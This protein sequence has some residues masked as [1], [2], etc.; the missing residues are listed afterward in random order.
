MTLKE[1]FSEY[2]IT[3]EAII[4]FQNINDDYD[5]GDFRHELLSYLAVDYNFCLVKD[6]P[7][8]ILEEEFDEYS[9]SLPCP[10]FVVYDKDYVFAPFFSGVTLSW[11]IE[12]ISRNPERYGKE[13]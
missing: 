6:L 4:E 7:R 5:I 13:T 10:D 3:S 8:E 11:R 2:P 1:W 12:K 9:D